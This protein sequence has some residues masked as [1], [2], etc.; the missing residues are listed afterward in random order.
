MLLSSPLYLEELHHEF[1]TFFCYCM[2]FYMFCYHAG[3]LCIYLFLGGGF[4]AF[5]VFYFG[6]GWWWDICIYGWMGENKN[7]FIHE[8]LAT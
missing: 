5:T 3:V 1:T 7:N 8:Y 2:L 4:V 6:A